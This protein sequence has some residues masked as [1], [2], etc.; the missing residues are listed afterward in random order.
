MKTEVETAVLPACRTGSSDLRLALV[1][2]G[3]KLEKELSVSL[4]YIGL[5]P[6]AAGSVKATILS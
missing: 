4:K 6:A 5:R 3:D 2:L 1:L